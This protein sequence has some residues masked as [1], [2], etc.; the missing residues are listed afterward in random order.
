ME[1]AVLRDTVSVNE[2]L[3][4]TVAEQSVECD[5]ILPDYCPD[6]LK[7][8][9]C[10]V[11][12]T[13]LSKNIMSD[14]LMIEGSAQVQLLYLSE[15]AEGIQ[16]FSYQMPFD[17]TLEL[18]A[19]VQNPF[20]MAKCRMNYANCR[21]VNSRKVDVRGAVGIYVKVGAVKNQ[22]TISDCTEP[23]VYLKK[24][25]LDCSNL[26]NCLS[27]QFTLRE[28]VEVTDSGSL[29]CILRSCAM[30]SVTDYK[31]VSNKVIMRGECKVC[32]VYLTND[33]RR[34][35]QMETE[36]PI[37]QIFDVDFVDEDCTV[38]MDLSVVYIR[39]EPKSSDGETSVADLDICIN[40]DIKAYKKS[41]CM[42]AGDA[43]S[44]QYELNLQSKPITIENLQESHQDN[45]V[46]KDSLDVSAD[47]MAEVYDVYGD[48]MVTSVI[49]KG[50]TCTCSINMVV[51]ILGE[52]TD[53][54]PCYCE[55]STAFEHNFTTN[56]AQGQPTA[57]INVS[58]MKMTYSLNSAGT[59]DISAEIAVTAQVISLSRE[60]VIF[61]ME[62]DQNKPKASG[63][64]NA[65]TLY[66][67]DAGEAV[68]DI[69]KN[70]NTSVDAVM[71][72]NGIESEKLDDRRMLLIPLIS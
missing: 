32:L 29:R 3:L 49:W 24:R 64:E 30:P 72:E 25:I 60:N 26:I 52:N 20:V 63:A 66:Y 13:I 16:T 50:N 39:A 62:A 56:E 8:L 2:V 68:W 9:K 23:K 51:S 40:A 45:A 14:K 59:L 10:K 19:S 12:P 44:T 6:I 35:Q 42:T 1:L 53:G 27:K 55:R 22:N 28:D 43:Y 31:V 38:M 54:L 34:P 65:L 61:E 57:E 69:A 58:L 36:I 37:S 47:S 4:D 17:K 41:Q 5:F 18:K 67:A 48:P 46:H 15:Q 71:E 11:A 33:G 70:Y 21:A 7:I